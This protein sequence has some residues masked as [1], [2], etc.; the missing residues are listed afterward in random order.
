MYLVNQIKTTML[1][2]MLFIQTS[3]KGGKPSHMHIWMQVLNPP[4]S[5]KPFMTKLQNLF[6]TLVNMDIFLKFKCCG[7]VV[8]PVCDSVHRGISVQ[9]SLSR[10]FCPGVS[11]Q[12]VSVQRGHCPGGHCPGGS[13]SRGSLSSGVSVQRIHCPGG[14]LS[15][16]SLSRGVYVQEGS[17]SRVSLSRGISVQGISVQGI[18][19]QGVSVKEGSVSRR[20][21]CQGDSSHTVTSG[22]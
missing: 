8:V 11:V 9:G 14:S 7:K 10:G 2:W 15:R 12:G 3:I 16:G 5:A 21:L 20:G 1:L 22:Q 13:L 18:S 19:V 6:L 4:T 17:L